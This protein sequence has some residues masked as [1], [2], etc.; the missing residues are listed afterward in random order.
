MIRNAVW[1]G[2]LLASWNSF[3]AQVIPQDQVLN[4]LMKTE[5]RVTDCW[6]EAQCFWTR[7]LNEFNQRYCLAIP[8]SDLSKLGTG[9]YLPTLRYVTYGN[10]MQGTWGIFQTN[11]PVL[12]PQ[13]IEWCKQ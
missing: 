5:S 2:L 10:L 3:A 11:A 12:T 4:V 6:Q 1:L 7:H 9:A 8:F 13:D